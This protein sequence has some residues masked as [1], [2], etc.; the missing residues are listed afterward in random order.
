MSA[1]E[2]RDLTRLLLAFWV[3]DDDM[4][5][6]EDEAQANALS[7]APSY[8]LDDVIPVSAETLDERL[9]DDSGRLARTLRGYLHSQTEPGYLAG[10][11]Q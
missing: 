8:T 11:E 5:A 10:Y 1:P 2:L 3:G 7:G 9:R 4:F 6:A